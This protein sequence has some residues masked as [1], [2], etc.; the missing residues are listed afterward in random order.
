[1]FE[2]DISH[3]YVYINF[4]PVFSLMPLIIFP[5]PNSA[6]WSMWLSGQLTTGMFDYMCA[7][8]YSVQDYLHLIDVEGEC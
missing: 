6:K 3:V 7:G 8:C 2:A 1:M 4:V 5:T